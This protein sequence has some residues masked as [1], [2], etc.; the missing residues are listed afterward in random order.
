MKTTLNI[1]LWLVILFFSCLNHAQAFEGSWTGSIQG[2]PL[3]FEITPLGDGYSAK[4]QSPKQSKNFFEMDSATVEDGLITIIFDAYKIKYV[5]ELKDGKIEGTFTQGPGSA[6]MTL[7]KKA[8]EEVVPDRPQEPK[9]PFPYKVEDV[10]FENPK[11]G[12]IKLA[13][14]LTMPADVENPPVAIMISG[15]G[16]QDR[17]EQLFFHKPFL[18]I[19]D[20][21]AKKGIAVL[22]YDDRGVA[23]SEGTQANATSLDFATDVEAA[24][25]FLKTR[26]DIDPEK[27]GLI[28]HSEGGLIAPIVIAANPKDIAFFVSLAGPGVSGTDVLLPQMQKSVEFQ[29]ASPEAVA[30]E[31]EIMEAILEKIKNTPDSSNQEVKDAILEIIETKADAAPENLGSKYTSEYA[32]IVASQFSDTWF[33]YF[34]SYDPTPYLEK[35]SCPVLALN[36]SLDYQ[37]IPEI[38]LPGMKSAFAKANNSDVTITIRPGLN[39]LF[40]NAITGSG[41][42][43]ATI[44]ETFDPATLDIIS[45]WINERF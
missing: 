8:Y 38:N 17:D 21:L 32:Q 18:V 30:L 11:A 6:P 39:H 31:M 19:A 13:G 12:N 10:V 40:Q 44:E 34:V 28:G 35:V 29:G 2:M 37:V 26:N 45:S 22:R 24:V 4:M 1:A 9:A 25:A 33:R 23:Q 36:G 42:E 16:P 27:I 20:H 15:S 41:S 3:I 14:T 43:Y 7:E 5:G